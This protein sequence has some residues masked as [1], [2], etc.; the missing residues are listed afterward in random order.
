MKTVA[1]E[2]KKKREILGPSH[3]GPHPSGP[4]PFGG[5]PFGA[6]T[7]CRLGPP[8]FGAHPL[9]SKNSTSKNWPKLKLAEV[10]IGRASFP[11]PP[12][13]PG[14]APPPRGCPGEVCLCEGIAGFGPTQTQSLV[15][16]LGWEH[17][18]PSPPRLGPSD[19]GWAGGGRASKSPSHSTSMQRRADGR[20]MNE[21]HHQGRNGKISQPVYAPCLRGFIQA[22]PLQA[23]TALSQ[24][25]FWP[26]WPK[27]RP[28]WPTPLWPIW[29]SD[30]SVNKCYSQTCVVLC[31][32]V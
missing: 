29:F 24:H 27:H 15:F 7:F 5:P 14:A 31:C 9:W 2:G 28:V 21:S 26:N 30:L 6:P 10:E 8:P 18:P 23:N 22:K 13:A 11:P 12:P 17:P 25:R 19:P 3:R 4:P 16:L 32:A 1:G 20:A